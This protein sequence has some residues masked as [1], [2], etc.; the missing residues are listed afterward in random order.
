MSDIK[1]CDRCGKAYEYD[2]SDKPTDTQG[3]Y[4]SDIVLESKDLISS[5]GFHKKYDLCAD[6]C[7]SLIGWLNFDM[8]EERKD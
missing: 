2:F 7:A 4:L 6:C 5:N 3:R 8:A 1:K